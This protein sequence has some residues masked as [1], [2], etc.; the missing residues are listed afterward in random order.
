ML[1][2][3]INPILPVFAILALGFLFGRMT[4]MSVEDAR[5]LNRFSMT[6]FVPILVF[7]LIARAP[8][9]DYSAAPVLG[10]IAA[11]GVVFVGAF[12]LARRLFRLD[13]GES[14]LL[15][16]CSVAAN[17]VF[18]GL[19]IALLI[20]GQPAVLPLTTVITLDATVSFALSM[21]ALQLITLG[22]AGPLSILRSLAKLPV[23][24]AIV[25]GAIVALL[26]V[27]IPP[28]IETFLDFNGSAAAPIALFALG[29]VLSR[30]ALQLD[31]RVGVFSVLKLVVFPAAVWSGLRI[32]GVAE[33]AAGLYLFASAGPS[34]TMAFSLALLF[35]V[36]TEIIAQV[37]VW[38]CVFSLLS[39]AV[40][41]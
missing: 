15:G 28:P 18:F 37:V 41:A 14:V 35:N 23:L 9:K 32:V 13:A 19:P 26:G 30:T 5:V 33:P 40:L 25:A 20:F 7:S 17:N 22:R 10:Y 36:R 31:A 29:V 3:L 1:E 6:V 11:Q 2:V 24:H 16:F 8:L 27:P 34:I 21:A 38:T 12:L 4:W 39:L